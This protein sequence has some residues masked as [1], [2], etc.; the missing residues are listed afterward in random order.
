MNGNDVAVALLM[1]NPGSFL[2]FRNISVQAFL[3][4]HRFFCLACCLPHSIQIVSSMAD[5]NNSLNRNLRVI[6]GLVMLAN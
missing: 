6:D 5:D 3:A 4:N 1:I 2:P